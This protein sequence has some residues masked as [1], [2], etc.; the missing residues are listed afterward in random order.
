MTKLIINILKAILPVLFIIIVSSMMAKEPESLFTVCITC[1]GLLHIFISLVEILFGFKRNYSRV[2]KTC[3]HK[4]ITHICNIERTK[5]CL[6]IK[7]TLAKW[8]RGC[9]SIQSLPN[10]TWTKP[11]RNNL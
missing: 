9:G 5:S 8:C 1:I 2:L 7:E 6:T 4:D 3:K 11:K 10:T